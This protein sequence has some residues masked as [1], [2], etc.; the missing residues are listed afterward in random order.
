MLKKTESLLILVTNFALASCDKN[1]CQ[2]LSTI[3]NL[4]DFTSQVIVVQ[5][6]GGHKAT[7]TACQ[8]EKNKSWQ[9]IFNSSWLGAI[10]KNG[11]ASIGEKQEGDYKTPAGIYELGTAF[12]SQPLALKMDYK[13]I[14]NEDKF[15]DD[16]NHSDYNMWATGKTNAKSY[17]NMLIK[18][19]KMGVV[20]NYNMKPT[21]PGKGSAIFMHL[22]KD[23]N[24]PTAG[25]IS[26]DEPHL[27]ALLYWLDKSQ[28]PYIMIS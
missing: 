5:G 2:N 18:S 24:R 25:C 28:H 1:A 4:P 15:I 20:V 17:E 27:L 3:K 8:R 19:Y 6:V 10:G 7:I 9:A 11:I 13:Y 23:P 21:L 16:T 26:M 12:G 22:R 14:T